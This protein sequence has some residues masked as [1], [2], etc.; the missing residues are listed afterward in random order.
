M[1]K[2]TSSKPTDLEKTLRAAV[3]ASGLTRYA[4][5]KGAGID[6]AVLL[7]FMSGQRTLTLPTAGKLADFLN[8]TLRPKSKNS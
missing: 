4:V 3:K 7:R 6:V 5:A 1:E 2:K 8:L